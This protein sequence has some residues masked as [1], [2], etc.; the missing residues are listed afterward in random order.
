MSDNNYAKV[1]YKGALMIPITLTSPPSTLLVPIDN[2]H[3]TILLGRMLKPFKETHGVSNA[4]IKDMM[5]KVAENYP[6]PIPQLGSVVQLA[7]RGNEYVA[8]YEFKSTAFLEVLNQAE[9]QEYLDRI[10][11]VLEIARH[12]RYFHVSIANDTG[13]PT[14]SIGDTNKDDVNRTTPPASL[15]AECVVIDTVDTSESLGW[16]SAM[17]NGWVHKMDNGCIHKIGDDE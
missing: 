11:D 16:E 6:A 15:N 1:V 2:P 9:M 7:C 3:C 8:P 13:K 12:E 10:C 14:D 17:D 4:V 5:K